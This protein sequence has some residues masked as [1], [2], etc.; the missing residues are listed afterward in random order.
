MD[1]YG[2]KVDKRSG[3]VNDLNRVDV[4]RYIVDLI[5]Q[6]ITVSLKTVKIIAGLPPL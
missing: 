1:Q 4:P 2:V 3:I 6:V 5:G